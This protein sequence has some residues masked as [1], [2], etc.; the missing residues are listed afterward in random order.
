MGQPDVYGIATSVTI[1]C[2][3]DAR[4]ALAIEQTIGLGERTPNLW[5]AWQRLLPTDPRRV[6]TVSTDHG[7]GTVTVTLTGGGTLRILGTATPG[8]TVAPR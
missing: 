1:T 7:D 2:Q 6:A 4:G 3:R 5:T 8:A